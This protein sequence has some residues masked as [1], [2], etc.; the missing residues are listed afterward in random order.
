MRLI[1]GITVGIVLILGGVWYLGIQ[2]PEDSPV[3]VEM[4]K[5]VEDIVSNAAVVTQKAV[6]KIDKAAESVGTVAIPGQVQDAVETPQVEVVDQSQEQVET[7]VPEVDPSTPEILSR[8]IFWKPFQTRVQASG[9]A[10]QLTKSS[11]VD[12]QAVRNSEGFYRI[13]FEYSDEVDLQNKISR[14]IETGGLTEL[15]L[16]QA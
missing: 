10:K 8:Q 16:D 9:F 12:C 11:G 7:P 15:Y 3:T 5:V 4:T 14:L 13:F 1:I 6:E 2:L